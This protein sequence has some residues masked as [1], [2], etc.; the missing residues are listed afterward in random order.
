MTHPQEPGELRYKCM[1]LKASV[2]GE[3]VANKMLE[4]WGGSRSKTEL[5]E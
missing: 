5:K 3:D 4:V 1:T 2:E